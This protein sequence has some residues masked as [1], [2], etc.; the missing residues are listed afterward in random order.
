MKRILVP[1]DFSEPSQRSYKFALDLAEAIEGE[2]FVL[3]LIDLPLIQETT[4]GIQ[5]PLMDK[6]LLK[7]FEEKAKAVF[8]YITKKYPTKVPVHF[9]P[10]HREIVPGILSFID[11][12]KI[13]L[14]VMS[15]HGASG[16]DEFFTG[17][18]AEVVARYS[19]VPVLATGKK[20]SFSKVKNII[21]PNTLELNQR[22][23]MR[24]VKQ[25]QDACHAKLHVLLINTASHFHT[26]AEALQLLE[27]FAY[28]YN[29]ENYTLN[30]RS[31]ESEPGGIADFADEVK[32]D[33][34]AMATHG[35]IGLARLVRGSIAESVSDLIEKPIWTLTTRK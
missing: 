10:A 24:R 4:F 9:F 21:F 16:F 3:H 31:N 28:H 6:S 33:L 18:T 11:T 7:P 22:D 35:R 29:L 1:T 17:S 5:P 15:T 23:L 26:D 14:V 32:G 25:L 27:K 19:P 34:V 8:K 20:A 13:D 30:H 12:K 2:V